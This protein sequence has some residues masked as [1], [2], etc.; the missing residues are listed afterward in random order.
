MASSLAEVMQVIQRYVPKGFNPR[1]GMILGSGLSSLAEQIVNPVS[2]PYQ[3]IPGLQTGN[4][5]GHA[6]LL[7]MGY[8]NDVPVVCL[9]GRLHL[10]EGV[11]YDSIRL[12]VRIVRK[13]GCNIFIVTGAAGSLRE[14]TE[15]GEL[16][17]INDHINFHPGNPL[18][19]PNDE[20]IG[21]RFLAMD[22]AYDIDLQDIMQTAADKLNITLHRG[23]Y[24]STLGPSFETPA[25]IRAFKRW[26]ADAVGMSVVPEV[27]LARHCGMRVACVAAITNLAAGLSKE[28]ISHDGTLHFGEL[29]ARKLTKLIPEFIKEAN[30]IYA[31]G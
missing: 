15:P 29:A 28:K 20:T 8:L 16:M 5:A 9:R 22:D 27:I 2:V 12:L 14:E 23:V 19:G 13:L 18:V 24:I 26:G 7:V 31:M 6:S 1:I 25:E 10:Y 17:M 4:V 30:S 21:P 11:S 3:A